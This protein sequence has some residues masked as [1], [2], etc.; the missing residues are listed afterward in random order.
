MSTSKLSISEAETLVTVLKDE[1]NIIGYSM[2]DWLRFPDV[3]VIRM[4]GELVAIMLTHKIGKHWQ[5]LAVLYVFPQHRGKHLGSKLL[6]ELTTKSLSK[7][8]R[9]L[10]ITRTTQMKKILEQNDYHKTPFTQLPVAVWWALF[11]NELKLYRFKEAMRKYFVFGVKRQW[12][13]YVC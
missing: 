5:E 4:D 1:P 11:T 6:K 12:E 13:Y 7:D 10:V 2:K 3:E 9:T 8:I